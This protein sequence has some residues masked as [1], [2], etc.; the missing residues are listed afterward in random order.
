[1][2]DGNIILYTDTFDPWLNLSVEEQLLNS[3]KP[4]Q[5]I[6][7]LWQNHNTVVIGKNQNAWRECK[8]ELLENEGGKLARR[9][10]GGGAVFHDIGNLNFTFVVDRENYDLTKQVS[11][12]LNA[13]NSLGINAEMNGRNDLTVDKRKFSGNA[14]C[15]RKHGA[16]HHGTV[17][18][19]ADMSKMARYLQVSKEKILSKG[20]QS[21]Q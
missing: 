13:V 2:P 21:V 4:G 16:Y 9:L 15:F 19:N 12:I 7:Y 5:F 1:M 10:S 6:L 20:I 18:V 3:V 8:T 14:F 17:L 11:V